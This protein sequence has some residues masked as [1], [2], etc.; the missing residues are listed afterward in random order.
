[1]LYPVSCLKQLKMGPL[2]NVVNAG[3]VIQ[4]ADSL[5]HLHLKVKIYIGASCYK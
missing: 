2:R 3:A 4:N 1:M 5:Q